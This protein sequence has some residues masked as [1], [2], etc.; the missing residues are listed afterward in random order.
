MAKSE[1]AELF[2]LDVKEKHLTRLRLINISKHILLTAQL[3]IHAVENSQR[4]EIN[5]S[6]AIELPNDTRILGENFAG[7]KKIH[8]KRNIYIYIH[9]VYFQCSKYS[10]FFEIL[11]IFFSGRNNEFEIKKKKFTSIVI[12]FI[13]K[14]IPD[15]SVKKKKKKNEITNKPNF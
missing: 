3:F 11:S 13:S 6:I 4:C 12:H 2:I 7:I 9:P 14:I 15:M 8:K 10:F 1:H 5:F